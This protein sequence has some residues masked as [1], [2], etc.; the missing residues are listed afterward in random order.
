MQPNSGTRNNVGLTTKCHENK[1]ELCG[2][3]GLKDWSPGPLAGGCFKEAN[4]NNPQ[5][6]LNVTVFSIRSNTGLF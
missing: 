3:E 2:L 5:H 1:E 4:Q 6:N